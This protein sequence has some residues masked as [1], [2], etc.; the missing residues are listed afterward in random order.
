MTRTAAVLRGGA[1]DVAG[2][3]VAGFALA[4]LEALAYHRIAP[5][6]ADRAAFAYYL[7]SQAPLAAVLFP[8]PVRPDT[9]AGYVQ[10]MAFAPL[11]VLFA[12]WAVASAVS[13]ITSR[14]RPRDFIGRLAA[15]A[16]SVL[17]ATVAAC[18]GAALGI[19]SGGEPVNVAG[20]IGAGVMLVVFAIAC[21]AI[22]IL[23]AQLTPEPAIVTTGVML[24][25]FFLNSLSRVFAQLSYARWIS[26]FRYFDLSA[27]LPPGGRFD[28][29]GFAMLIAIA[30]AGSALAV[31][32]SRTEVTT[33]I[34]ASKT[35]ESSSAR[36]LDIPVGRDLYLRRRA[37][38]AWSLAAVVLGAF[39]A[40][41]ARSSIQPLLLLPPQLPGI[42]QLIA[43]MYT[44]LL[45]RMW[46]DVTLLL[47]AALAIVFVSRWSAEVSDGRLATVLSAPY[48]RAT[49]VVERVAALS[50]ATAVL[51]AM[52]GLAVLLTSR[53]AGMSV[54]VLRLVDACLMLLMFATVVGAAGSLFAAWVPQAATALTG[55]F[56][57]AGYLDDQVGGSLGWPGWLQSLSP[58]NLVR[59]PL[60]VGIDGRRLALMVALAVVGLASSILLMQ[61]RDV[62]LADLRKVANPVQRR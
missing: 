45:G 60:L 12:S 26:P 2:F 13:F 37:F 34:N 8:P 50:T 53:G 58:F 18:A 6:G 38:A 22:C 4:L 16:I 55:V 39:L 24:A 21:Y 7:T 41:A 62:G 28:L 47:F 3:A 51:A 15:F 36:L 44:L 19:A 11:A 33:R 42:H 57:L 30:V 29:G 56:V 35:F 20:V 49:V 14:A 31:L 32:R 46:F 48:S 10:M 40:A 59:E 5:T 52:S 27:P 23:V 61:R 9:A 17:I 43:G 25:L 1:W 54:D